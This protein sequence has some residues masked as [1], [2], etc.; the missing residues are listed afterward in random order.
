MEKKKKQATLTELAQELAAGLQ[1]ERSAIGDIKIY[2]DRQLQALKKQDRNAVEEA[3]LMTSQEVN[4]LY[5]LRNQRE[6]IVQ[7]M[8]GLLKIKQEKPK[9]KSLVIALASEIKDRDVKSQL[10]TLAA[11]LPEEASMAKDSC[12]ELAY[13]LQY[14]LHLGQNLIEAIHG[15]TTPA[16]VKVYTA[17]GNKEL[18]SNHRMMVN[19]VG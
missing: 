9:L 3:T 11:E 4:T 2:V 19:K 1:E 6:D 5:K 12:K 8:A 10:A 13:S 18:S 17:A 14:A 15:S 7:K 16:P